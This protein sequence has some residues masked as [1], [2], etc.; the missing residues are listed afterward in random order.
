MKLNTAFVAIA[1]AIFS[2]AVNA[3]TINYDNSVNTWTLEGF[4]NNGVGSYTNTGVGLGGAGPTTV[5]GNGMALA[6]H[7]TGGWIYSTP[8]LAFTDYW[9]NTDFTFS[10]AGASWS[11]TYADTTDGAFSLYYTPGSTGTLSLASAIA[12]G[13]ALDG[14]FSYTAASTLSNAFLQYT[15]TAAVPL[16]A[17]LPLML[18]GLGALGFMRRRRKTA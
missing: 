14:V 5:V 1:L 6:F 11:N 13:T 16:P 15:P 17:S 7:S 4:Q 9:H 3:A 18:A 12:D 8:G 2:P 10:V